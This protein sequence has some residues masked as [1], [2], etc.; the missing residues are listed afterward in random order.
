MSAAPDVER[1]E[2]ALAVARARMVNLLRMRIGDSRVI[3]AM[4]SVPRE[5]FVP[6]HLRLRAY[7]DCALPIA[8]DQT[9]SQPTMVA[10]MLEAALLRAEDHALEIGTG[11]G[12]GAAVLSRLVRDVVTVERV[13]LLAEGA[14]TVL[15]AL[16]YDN[17]EVCDAGEVLGWTE[18]APY[19]A[20][21]VTA[22]AP[23]VPRSLLDQLADGGRLVLPVGT[24]RSQELVR[25]TKT[26]HG[27]ELARLGECAFV[28][29][30]GEEA[31]DDSGAS[32]RI[33]EP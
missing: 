20:I 26:P 33:S 1:D 4:A 15:R 14:R 24:L 13:P 23:H 27:V 31:W 12:Y 25:A 16:G 28:P 10:I 9:I 6:P 17:V 32:E 30:I 11:S 29:L 22:G 18:R 2:A 3:E 19:D 5:R 21:I 8:A 7:D